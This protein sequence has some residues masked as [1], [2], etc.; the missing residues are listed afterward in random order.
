[1]YKG[2][3][4]AYINENYL[5]LNKNY[6]FAKISEEKQKYIKNNHEKK[7]IDLSIGDV[8]LPLTDSEIKG[9]NIASSNLSKKETF[10][11][12]PPSSGH[13][14]LKKEIIKNDYLKKNISIDNSELFIGDSSKSD[15]SNILDI[16]DKN[17]TVA[18]QD[19][20]YPVYVDSNIIRGNKIIYINDI[21][22]FLPQKEHIDIIYLCFPNNP[23]G[24]I[25]SKELLKKYVDYAIENDTII[26]FDSAYEAFIQ[27][28]N[29]VHSI[30]EIE[31]AKK[32]AVEFR[33]FSKTAGFTSIRLAYT[34]VPNAIM[35]HSKSN[36]NISLNS[37]FK[38]LK[39]TKY[40]GPSYISEYAIYNVYE[41]DK[42]NEL[43]KNINYYLRNTTLLAEFFKSK[44]M[45]DASSINSP[46]VWIKCKD[47]MNSW[48]F[49]YYMLNNFSIIGT[50]GIGFGANGEGHFRLTGFG[51]YEDTIEAINR[52]DKKL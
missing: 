4:M 8:T 19:P 28:K 41:S 36:K 12:Y 27:D 21:R 23:T 30:Y 2:G 46:Y 39:D 5:N 9:I 42:L 26:F 10:T 17:L 22:T 14:F 20:V 52:M 44:G 34:I 7:L 16:F 32:V 15:I 47:N 1:M 35:L 38:R 37:M 50:P 25:I 43:Q 49:F 33:S 45:I 31:N 51:T 11:G 29:T 3:F 40:N 18:L 48:D 13:D 24:A 6:L